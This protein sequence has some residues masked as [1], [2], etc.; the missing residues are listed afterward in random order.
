[1]TILT[2]LLFGPAREAMD[3]S[4]IKVEVRSRDGAADIKV[5]DLRDAV[6]EQCVAL[7]ELMAVSR[8]S[9]DQELIRDESGTVITPTSEI[10]LI[11]PIS[12]G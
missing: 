7:K 8:F 5:C 2:V 3:A 1:M 12:G 10:A 11:P 6:A 4:D 9:V